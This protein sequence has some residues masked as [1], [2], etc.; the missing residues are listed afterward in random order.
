MLRTAGS[1]AGAQDETTTDIEVPEQT[2]ADIEAQRYG[3]YRAKPADSGNGN[4]P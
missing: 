2:S 3:A 1:L 4:S